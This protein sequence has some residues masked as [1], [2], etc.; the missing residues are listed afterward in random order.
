MA[1]LGFDVLDEVQKDVFHG[2][3]EPRIVYLWF[4]YQ[5]FLRLVV[6]R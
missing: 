6:S 2:D 4:F 1:A 3:V 5:H